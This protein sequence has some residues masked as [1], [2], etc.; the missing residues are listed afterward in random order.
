MICSATNKT[1]TAARG[2]TVVTRATRFAADSTI[3]R[4]A[5]S[6][7]SISSASA[8]PIRSR[9]SM[10]SAMWAASAARPRAVSGRRS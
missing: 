3:R 2:E 9:P 10:I 8:R 7:G 5:S 6:M 1:S 4:A